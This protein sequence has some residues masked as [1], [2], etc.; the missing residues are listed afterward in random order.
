MHTKISRKISGVSD[1]ADTKK[2][3]LLKIMNLKSL[4]S[5]T[6]GYYDKENVYNEHINHY[7]L[8]SNE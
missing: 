2:T 3:V 6:K 5:L 7:N 4:L 8:E 1:N